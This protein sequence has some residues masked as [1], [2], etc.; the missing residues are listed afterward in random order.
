[1]KICVT[2][3][4][5]SADS[6]MDARFGRA[7]YF[8]IAD[9]ESMDF[10]S[11]QNPAALAGGGAGVQSGQMMADRGIKAVVTGN[12]GPNA[13]NVLNASG[14]E[15]YRGKAVSVNENVE[16][17]KAGELEKINETVQSHFGMGGNK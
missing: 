12:V 7:E 10:E 4:G 6:R 3:S 11:V 8:I 2:S 14:I 16:K 1:M 15:V 5:S 9:T 13:M 17:F